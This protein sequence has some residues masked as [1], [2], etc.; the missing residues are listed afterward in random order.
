MNPLQRHLDSAPVNKAPGFTYRLPCPRIVCADGTSISVQAS[1]NHYC[2]PNND[3]G[4]WTH[5]EVGF[6]SSP[7]GSLWHDYAE[8]PDNP[9]G[10]V[11]AYVPIHLV[12]W[13]IA[14]HGGIAGIEE[15][16]V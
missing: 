9:T 6:P 8:D 5:V 16:Q 10:T 2:T 4:P 1:Q 15:D 13:Y 12:I 14:A 11:Y 7:P 3:T